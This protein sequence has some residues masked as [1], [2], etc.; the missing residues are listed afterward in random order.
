LILEIDI[1]NMV[2]VKF[3]TGVS[4]PKHATYSL[5]LPD[6]FFSPFPISRA[7]FA[8]SLSYFNFNLKP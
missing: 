2:R 4:T 7:W 6:I 3:E 5:G 8:L 1:V